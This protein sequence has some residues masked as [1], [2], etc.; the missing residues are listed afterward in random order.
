METIS[1]YLPVPPSSSPVLLRISEEFHKRFRRVLSRTCKQHESKYIVLFFLVRATS[2]VILT[3]VG[4]RM[5]FRASAAARS[6]TRHD[7][8]AVE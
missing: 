1:T 4:S 5:Y 7:V 6:L 2:I 3:R 8:E